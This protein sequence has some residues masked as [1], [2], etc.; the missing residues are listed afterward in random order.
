MS[1]ERF[2]CKKCGN[3]KEIMIN[4]SECGGNYNE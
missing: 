3:F 2:I 1:E 4:M